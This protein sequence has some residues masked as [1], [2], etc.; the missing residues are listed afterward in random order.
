MQY[1][2]ISN[3]TTYF[4]YKCPQCLMPSVI[5]RA[6]EM[7]FSSIILHPFNTTC[8]EKEHRAIPTIYVK[9]LDHMD[10][11]TP[12]ARFQIKPIPRMYYL[13]HLW[14]FQKNAI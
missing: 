11:I 7:N 9:K 1:R 5:F 14:N 8:A 6:E 10:I 13:L 4:L 3:Q 12:L 2:I